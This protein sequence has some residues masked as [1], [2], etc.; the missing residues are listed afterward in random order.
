M[1]CFISE[2][3]GPHFHMYSVPCSHD[4]QAS[5]HPSPRTPSPLPRK[6]IVSNGALPCIEKKGLTSAALSPIVQEYG[7]PE[8]GFTRSSDIF[9]AH[10]E[11]GDISSTH[12]DA[13]EDGAHAVSNE[14]SD[15][16]VAT[17]EDGAHTVSNETSHTNVVTWNKAIVGHVKEGNVFEA[18]NA[19]TEMLCKEVEPNRITFICMIKACSSGRSIELGRR[20][21]ACTVMYGLEW[22]LFVANTL[23]DMYAKC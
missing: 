15:R 12:I 3:L 11:A 14:T 7:N 18:F 22:A 13:Y 17:Y 16:N 9:N 1:A 21:H 5:T 2:T 19:F 10:V 6:L 8:Q 4:T 20:I 23:I